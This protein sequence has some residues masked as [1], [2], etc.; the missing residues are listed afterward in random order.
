MKIKN[1]KKNLFKITSSVSLIL[2]IGVPAHAMQPLT[3]PEMDNVAT[4]M[5]NIIGYVAVFFLASG[6]FGAM[7]G[8]H[9]IF[10]SIKEQ[11][12]DSRTTSILETVA[13]LGSIVI[14]ASAYIFKGYITT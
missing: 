7:H 2:T 4:S 6:A 10:Q 3:L 14:G 9:K 1:M 8:G 5:Q 11:S 12:G 13:G